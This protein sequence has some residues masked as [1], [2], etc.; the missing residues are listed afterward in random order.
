MA[1]QAIQSAENCSSSD[2]NSTVTHKAVEAEAL[3][4]KKS[5]E[6]IARARMAEERLSADS[7]LEEAGPISGRRGS[8]DIAVRHGGGNGLG[9]AS[10]GENACIAQRGVW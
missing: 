6:A 10:G 7:V 8:R 4:Q 2:W 5:A 3:A 1:E 9:E